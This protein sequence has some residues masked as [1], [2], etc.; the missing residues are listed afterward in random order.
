MIYFYKIYLTSYEESEHITLY[1]EEQLSEEELHLRFIEA[2]TEAY[3]TIKPEE[4]AKIE[5]EKNDVLARCSDSQLFSKLFAIEEPLYKI[6]KERYN[7][8]QVAFEKSANFWGWNS[9]THIWDAESN[10]YDKLLIGRL[11]YKE[12]IK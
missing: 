4:D 6:L 1:S 9:R 10:E 11:N 12:E 3:V 8:H 2:F 5:A 7:L